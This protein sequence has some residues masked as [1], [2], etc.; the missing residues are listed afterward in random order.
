M[1]NPPARRQEEELQSVSELG[2]PA[3]F[4]GFQHQSF[5]DSGPFASESVWSSGLVTPQALW[6]W[7]IYNSLSSAH[8]SAAQLVVLFY[9]PWKTTQCFVTDRTGTVGTDFAVTVAFIL[10][11]F[12]HHVFEFWLACDDSV[13]KKARYLLSAS[14]ILVRKRE[15]GSS[16]ISYHAICAIIKANKQRYGK[17]LLSRLRIKRNTSRIPVGEKDFAGRRVEVYFEQR[18]Q[19]PWSYQSRKNSENPEQPP[20]S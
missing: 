16:M 12:I 10:K 1:R 15:K 2:F 13:L 9:C 4:K 17:C 7:V 11:N 8:A 19:Y 5:V 18:E 20:E 6:F 3:K 14:V